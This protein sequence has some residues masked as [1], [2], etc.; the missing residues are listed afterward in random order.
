VSRRRI[1]AFVLG[2]AVTLAGVVLL[3]AGFGWGVGVAVA[4][5]ALAVLT[6]PRWPDDDEPRNPGWMDGGPVGPA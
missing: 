5:F 4:G 6:A 2:V 3:V 1:A